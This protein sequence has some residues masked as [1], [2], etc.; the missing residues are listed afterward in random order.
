MFPS[1]RVVQFVVAASVLVSSP[2]FSQ[3]A[4]APQKP[5]QF[6]WIQSPGQGEIAKKAHIKLEGP[7]VFLDDT[8]TKKF[9]TATGNIAADGQYTLASKDAG[10]FAIFGYVGEGYVKDDEK[11]D[12][13]ALLK[14]L[15]SN[16]EKSLET[17]K[18]QNL[19]LIYLDDWYIPPHYDAETKRLEW[20]VKLHDQDNA[21]LVNFTTRLLGR[22]GYMSATL[23]SN[24]NS[25]NQDIA[26]FKTALKGYA[27][28]PGEAYAEFTS[29]DKV[30]AYGLG[31][32]VVGGAAA[33][34]ASK[35]GFKFLG[36]LFVA[37]FAAVAAFFKKIFGKK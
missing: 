22:G 20:A 35:G 27:Y 4:D 21:Q 2:A 6:A 17:R 28:N 29:G 24:P 16:N 37:G 15:R 30:A 34:V 23:V 19:P 26:S 25:L 12:P 18:Q 5:P 1:V 33:A 9:L 8:E 11:I 31:A 7:L 36:Y 32:L 10:W 13:D 3:A 14:M